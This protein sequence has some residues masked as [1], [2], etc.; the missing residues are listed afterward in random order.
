M[1]YYC[2]KNIAI[3]TID[4]IL[5]TTDNDIEQDLKDQEEYCN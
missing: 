1:T 2:N 3:K 4:P 5:I